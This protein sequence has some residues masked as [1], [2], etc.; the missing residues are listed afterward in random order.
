MS[1]IELIYS[2]G[3]CSLAPHILLHEIKAKFNL[4]KEQVGKFSPELLALNPKARIPVL[5]IGDTLITENPAIM[6]AIS[7]LAPD[8]QLMGKPNTIEAAH[9]MEWLAW[10]SGTLHGNAFALLL[11]PARFSDNAAHH[12]ELQAKGKALIQ[13]CFEA[14]EGRL[15]G[16]SEYA[17]GSRFTAVDAFLFVFY[18]WARLIF[19]W[20]L[21]ALYPKYTSLAISV[22]ARPSAISA[23][24]AEGVSSTVE[25]Q[26]TL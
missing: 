10:L 15:Q 21:E 18:R 13:N 14:I 5:L 6:T 23:L 22:A 7:G 26:H 24:A 17:V 20:D 3:A 12:K 2:P 4:R 11:R 19:D 16:D 1:D 8:K 25:V 9:V